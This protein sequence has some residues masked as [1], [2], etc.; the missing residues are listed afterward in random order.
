M[1]ERK[2]TLRGVA[3]HRYWRNAIHGL[4]PT[5]KGAGSNFHFR[6]LLW[7]NEIIHSASP[8]FIYDDYLS[9]HP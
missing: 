3:S 1:G 7:V 6:Y 9:M 5:E 2:S 8:P 4:Y